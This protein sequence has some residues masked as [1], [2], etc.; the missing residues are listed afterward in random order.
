MPFRLLKF[1][2]SKEYPE[3]RMFRR[4]ER[5][6]DRYDA[7]IIGAGGHGLAAA[8]H[9]ARDH[10]ITDVAVLDRGYVGGGNTGRNTAIVRSNYLTI[11]GVK[12]YDEFLDRIPRS[13]VEKIGQTVHDHAVRVRVWVE[14]PYGGCGRMLF[15]SF[16]AALIVCG[17]SGIS[18]G[19]GM[20]SDLAKKDRVGES[21]LK[22]IE[23]VWVVQDARTTD[24]ILPTLLELVE[25]FDVVESRF[26][27]D[28]EV[29][30]GLPKEILA[31]RDVGTLE[32]QR[33]RV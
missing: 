23:L 13:E 25:E 2:L 1:A 11:E 29:E 21:R 24:A 8:Y 4:P 28:P 33:D 17:G 27:G 31:A 26:D 12:F 3:P 10:G 18:F 14:G 15:P 5:L 7:V 6:K 19:L 32:K 9:L 30:F 16:S 22:Y 20:L